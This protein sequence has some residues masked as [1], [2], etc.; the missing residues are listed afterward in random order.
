MKIFIDPGHN[1]ESFDTGAQGNGLEEQDV[2]FDIAETLRSLLVGLGHEVKMSRN[3]KTDSV[4]NSMFTSIANRAK[5][6]NDWKADL[7][8][9]IH[10]NAFNTLAR[11]TETLV[12]SQNSLSVPY[13]ERIQA[14]IVKRLGTADRG[15]KT[16]TNLGVLW[17][18]NMP[19]LLVECAF[20][21]NLHDAK[22]LKNNV[23]D[24]AEAICC[25]ILGE[26]KQTEE[27]TIVLELAERGIISDKQLWFSKLKEDKNSY[28]LAKKCLTF[29]K[30]VEK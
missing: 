30:G 3:T 18:T 8:V 23:S 1:H 10:C 17:R 12:Y 24:F 21:D 15:V 9:S 13:A 22:L 20:I 27:E 26:T 6:A 5:M 11:G 29:I 25:G 19:A 14:E 2:N 16:R 7:F 28:W 4:G